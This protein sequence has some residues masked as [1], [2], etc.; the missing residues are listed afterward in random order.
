MSFCIV[1][2]SS[3]GNGFAIAKSLKNNNHTVIGVDLVETNNI[4]TSYFIKGSVTEPEIIKSCF[5]KFL[6]SNSDELYLI[7]NA[8]ITIPSFPH[9]E[10]DWDRT[11]E[12]NL[13]APFLWSNFF[14]KNVLNNKIKKGGIIFLGSLATTMGFPENP[15]YQAAKCGIVGLTQS[16]AY[17]LG[18]YGIRA[19]C[20][21]PGYIKTNMTKKSYNDERL[22]KERL[23]HMLIKRWGEPEDVSNLVNFLCSDE[24]SYITGANI[25]VD[26]GWNI[27][28]L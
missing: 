14:L 7:N 28:G 26:G 15:S 22:N 24:S 10:I 9:S 12:I 17:D 19:N 5:K 13:K 23:S 21:S 4:N 2:G 11:I 16:F 3:S 18:K 27:C 1:T 8:G 25:P 20:V 6:D